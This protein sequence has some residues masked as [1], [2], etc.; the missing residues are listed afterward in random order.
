MVVWVSSMGRLG[1]MTD[2][3]TGKNPLHRALSQI[4]ESLR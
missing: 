1:M 4:S 2:G 3:G